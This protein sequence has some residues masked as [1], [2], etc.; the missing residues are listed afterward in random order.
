MEAAVLV[1]G[2]AGLVG[3]ALTRTLRASGRHVIAVDQVAGD[4]DGVQVL[5]GDVCDVHRLH[6]LAGAAGTLDAVVHCAAHSGP[7]VARDRSASMV[8]VNVVGTA[9]LREV[10]R[11]HGARRFVFASSATVFGSTGPGPIN[12]QHLPAPASLYPASKLASEHLVDAYAHQYG[13]DGV[14]LRLSWV[15]GPRRATDCVIRELLLAALQGRT[16]Q[17][18]YGADFHRQ[19][20]HLDDVVRALTAA[21]DR[22]EP[23][24]RRVLTITGG[25]YPT[26]PQVAAAV[27]DVLPGATAQFGCGPDPLDPPQGRF[28]LSAAAAELGY[29]PTVPLSEGIARYATWLATSAGAVT[30][31]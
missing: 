26:L 28:D 4:I 15:Y 9:N 19:F 3:H 11:I 22:P 13:L 6:E 30:V 5:A 27:A 14:S 21:V 25:D 16:F 7:M 1:T 10:A 29:A 31:R 2:A 8:A 18:P 12:E 17:L 24:Q 20:V 23:F